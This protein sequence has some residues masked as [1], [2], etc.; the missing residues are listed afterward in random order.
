MCAIF[1][2]VQ[3]VVTLHGIVLSVIKLSV[4]ILSVLMLSVTTL[5][6]IMLS[7]IMLSVIMQS[8]VMR[9]VIMRIVVMRSVII[10]SVVMPSVVAPPCQQRHL[11]ANAW[12]NSNKKTYIFSLVATSSCL[13][14]L[15]QGGQHLAR[16]Y[17]ETVRKGEGATQ[18]IVHFVI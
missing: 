16:Q 1:I 9:S 6:V 13:T 17:D 2:V 4:I 7:V 8:V 3:N 11:I 15:P 12:T 5:S 14:Y 18:P 10:R